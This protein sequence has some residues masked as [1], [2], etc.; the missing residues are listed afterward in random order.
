MKMKA[1][2]YLSALLC[3]VFSANAATKEFRF[4]SCQIKKNSLSVDA[5]CAV[6][7]RLED[8]GKPE[9]R[10]I[11]IHVA[12]F[13][14]RSPDPEMDAFTIIQGGPG[15]S[16]IDLYLSMRRVFSGIRAKRDILVIDQR[17]TGRSNMLTCE[18]NDE[19]VNAEFSPELTKKIARECL[20]QLESDP[21]Y[22]TTSIAVQ[23][24][25]AVRE[26]SGYEQ[27]SIYGV[28]YGTRVAQHYLRRFPGAT[29]AVVL[30]GVADTELNLAGSEIA[31][32]SQ[33]AFDSMIA[34]CKAEKEC[35]DVF[36]DIEANFSFQRELLKE[37]PI[38]V[39]LAHP[40]SGEIKEQSLN[41][42]HLLGMVRLMPYSTESLALLPLL[43]HEAGKGNYVPLAAQ[44]MLTETKFSND[45]AYA[46]NNSVVCAEDVPFL[47][48]GD[49]EGDEQTYF[50]KTVSE[51]MRALCE[52]WPK[53]PVDA[54]FRE[55]FESTVPVLLLSGETDPITPAENAQRALKMFS[56]A[57]H[58][59]A[60]A[61]GHGV[62]G[63]GCIPQLATTFIDEASVENL[64]IE[65]V[66]R[67]RAFPFFLSPTG[68]TP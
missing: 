64:S 67:E 19:L 17:G 16:S 40:I 61:H 35:K 10:Q 48:A 11:E 53:G 39:R 4:E 68:P 14:S 60:P 51:G 59:V 27:L 44:A 66:D 30:D 1:S 2:L 58:I 22:Y 45:Y 18:Q 29:R 55:P 50:G 12:R 37:S 63:R 46:M 54:D 20:D 23:D 8:P 57:L 21:R 65:C 47:N 43:L 38:S 31:I 36:G 25:E 24:L 15:M 13:P 56:N 33:Q 9:G 7:K 28:S 41:E 5:E 52:I 6:L 32:R 49:L 42:Q 3:V 34:R 62:V 26:G